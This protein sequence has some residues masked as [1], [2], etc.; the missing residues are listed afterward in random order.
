MNLIPW[1]NKSTE[2]T[3]GGSTALSTLRSDMDRLFD[4]FV[5]EPF[6]ALDWSFGSSGAWSP[7]V[8]L[9][10]SD[11]EYTVRA[12]LPG[13][14]PDDLNVSVTENQLT[15]SGEKRETSEKK[16]EGYYHSESRYGSFCRSIPLP[17]AID[18]SQVDAEYKNGVLTVHLAKSPEN[19]PK[20]IDVKVKTK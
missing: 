1:K 11:T 7:A 9:A 8:D 17:G 19:T 18:S 2:E 5:R 10:E 6:G 4:A 14:D 12:E 3:S 16:E 13:L 20:H 15:L